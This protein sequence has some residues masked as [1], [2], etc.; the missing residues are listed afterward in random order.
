MIVRA[1]SECGSLWNMDHCWMLNSNWSLSYPWLTN[2]VCWHPA[3][4]I[5]VI[6]EEVADD[7]AYAGISGEV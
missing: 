4:T 6:D 1:C 5:L 2:K 3:G 7:T